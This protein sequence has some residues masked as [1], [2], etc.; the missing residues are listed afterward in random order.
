MIM[1]M[2]LQGDVKSENQSCIGTITKGIHG[3]I[4]WTLKMLPEISCQTRMVLWRKIQRQA[5]PQNPI[6]KS[7]HCLRRWKDP[8]SSSNPQSDITSEE[9]FK[10][11]LRILSTIQSWFPIHTPWIR[12][13]CVRGDQHILSTHTSRSSQLSAITLHTTTSGV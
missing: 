13:I 2:A 6:I 8:R 5:W 4:D 10:R 9:H 7:L 12:F 3:T 1:R 11:L